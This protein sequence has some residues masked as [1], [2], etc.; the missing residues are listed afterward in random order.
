MSTVAT[1]VPRLYAN[2]PTRETYVLLGIRVR[3]ALYP[4]VMISRIR[5]RRHLSQQH[6]VPEMV[7]SEASSLDYFAQQAKNA[8]DFG[9]QVR[10]NH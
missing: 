10:Q 7:H 1:H 4:V 2:I 9:N 3:W 8:C 5:T 6:V